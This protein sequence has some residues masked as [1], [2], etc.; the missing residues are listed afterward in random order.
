MKAPHLVRPQLA[1][2]WLVFVTALVWCP[3]AKPVFAQEP[4]SASL[5][6]SPT[7]DAAVEEADASP[8]PK[9]GVRDPEEAGT[10]APSAS[11]TPDAAVAEADAPP[12]PE[13]ATGSRNPEGQD[14]V[15]ETPGLWTSPDGEADETCHPGEPKL[16]RRCRSRVERYRYWLGEKLNN[17]HRM[18][19]SG[20]LAISV[21]ASCHALTYQCSRWANVGYRNE[22]HRFTVLNC[23]V[24]E[25]VDRINQ[26]IAPVPGS[27]SKAH[28]PIAT[29]YT[30]IAAGI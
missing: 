25:H 1:V 10:P 29:F 13:S 8:T 14:E 3:G 19:D 28:R 4:H 22:D 17:T 18:T 23:T 15:T 30:A 12:T 6:A 11:A 20:D 9:S 5:R 16:K 26:E 24:V 2:A 21:R 27:S 7:P